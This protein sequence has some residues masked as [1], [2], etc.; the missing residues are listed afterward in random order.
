MFGHSSAIGEDMYGRLM[1]EA[2]GER[3]SSRAKN[4]YVSQEW[5]QF[6]KFPSVS[7]GMTKAPASFYDEASRV[8]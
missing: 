1:T 2:P 8:I 3:G 6:L 5:H 4:R 7:H